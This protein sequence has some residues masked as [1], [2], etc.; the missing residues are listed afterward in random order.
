MLPRRGIQRFPETR[1]KGDY[2]CANTHGIRS[3]QERSSPILA[4]PFRSH[5]PLRTNDCPETWQFRWSKLPLFAGISYICFRRQERPS[6]AREFTGASPSLYLCDI[7]NVF[8]I[9][10]S[11]DS[12][13]NGNASLTFTMSNYKA[14]IEWL[15][16][17]AKPM[18]FPSV[19]C[20]LVLLSRNNH[21][22][23]NNDVSRFC[24]KDFNR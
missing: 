20:E 24:R 22:R 23:K 2:V 16:A 12:P 5:P 9:R 8:G 15:S 6:H 21:N 14:D 17:Y 13:P 11:I 4:H 1:P 19:F 10:R 18:Y 3:S 7:T